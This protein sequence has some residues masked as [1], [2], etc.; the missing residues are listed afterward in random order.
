M[1]EVD[2]FHG[3]R[4]VEQSQHDTLA[5]RGRDR[6]DAQIDIAA[7]DAQADSAVLRQALLGDIEARHDLDARRDRR[8]K[9][10]GRRQ[11]VVHHAVHAEAHHHFF[12]ENF[13]VNIRR[14][15]LDRL[16]Q[17]AVD[18]L[19]DRR[20]VVGL[21]QVQRLRREFVGDY[22]EPLF[23]QIDHQVFGRSGRR[24]VV[25]AVD[26]LGDHFGRRDHYI[27]LR[28]KQDS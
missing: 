26:R 2:S 7:R 16:R 20:R 12:F 9:A 22:V 19:D 4:A 14:A 17:H 25:R 18:E 13:D 10:L 6:R 8:L 23:L 27:D 11:H 5:E 24:L 15:I 28:A 1:I 3:L 21:E